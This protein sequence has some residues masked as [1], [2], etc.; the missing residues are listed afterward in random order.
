[1]PLSPGELVA[2]LRKLGCEVIQ[3]R[4]KGSHMWVQLTIDGRQRAVFNIPTGRD[5]IAK[6]TLSALL[7]SNGIRDEDH[8]LELLR[9]DDP[10]RAFLLLLPRVSPRYRMPS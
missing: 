8:L 9:A 10:Q 3:G 4:G 2:A 6:G 1:M 5:P 7:K